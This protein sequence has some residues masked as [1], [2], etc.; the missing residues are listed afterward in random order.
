MTLQTT[1]RAADELD[2][3]GMAF[4]LV[5]HDI[6]KIKAVRMLS[7]SIFDLLTVNLMAL[8]LTLHSDHI[9]NRKLVSVP[10]A[11]HNLQALAT[12]L[13]DDCS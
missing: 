11:S 6:T 3:M 8:R 5:V 2:C 9:T 10:S 7:L 13:T 4:I 1:C 12:H